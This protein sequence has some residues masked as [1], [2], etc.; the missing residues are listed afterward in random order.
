MIESMHGLPALG[1]GASAPVTNFASTRKESGSGTGETQ[2]AS[3]PTVPDQPPVTDPVPANPTPAT[4]NTL[5]ADFATSNL[6]AGHWA[7]NS[8]WSGILLKRKDFTQSIPMDKPNSPSTRRNMRQWINTLPQQQ[9]TD[10]NGMQWTV[11][12]NKSANRPMLMFVPSKFL[13]PG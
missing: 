13:G 1:Q 5:S 2:V 3:P 9:F 6:D 11:V 10:A 7:M 8:T 12:E 4:P